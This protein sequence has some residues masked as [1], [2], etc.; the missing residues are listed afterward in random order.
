MQTSILTVLMAMLSVIPAQARQLGG[1]ETL[2]SFECQIMSAAGRTVL[3][4]D[5]KS[6]NRDVTGIRNG[7][8]KVTYRLASAGSYGVPM[9]TRKAS[10]IS[11]SGGALGQ[12]QY[13]T[14]AFNEILPSGVNST[15]GSVLFSTV[16]GSV[17]APVPMGT[18]VVG[19]V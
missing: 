17:F 1:L 3:Q 16:G 7:F 19:S 11:I 2:V 4:Y 6:K 12:N 15:S 8:V 5:S 18:T 13:L 10:Q 14:M 9:S